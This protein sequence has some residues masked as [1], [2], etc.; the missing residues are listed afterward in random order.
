[1]TDIT[2]ILV[3]YWL[4][5]S[6]VTLYLLLQVARN[7]MGSL[8]LISRA[9]EVPLYLFC[10]ICWPLGISLA[11]AYLLKEGEFEWLFKER[12]LSDWMER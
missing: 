5:P 10:S 7:E 1:M 2:Q 9:G 3:L 6:L 12:K 8:E 4:L 11:F